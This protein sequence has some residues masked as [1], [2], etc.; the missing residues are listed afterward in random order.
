MSSILFVGIGDLNG[1]DRF[2]RTT[3]F[4]NWINDVSTY[5]PYRRVSPGENTV[6][7]H[8][9][10]T[11]WAEA[12]ELEQGSEPIRRRRRRLRG[13]RGASAKSL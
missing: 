1:S 2:I 3:G 9:V 6:N 11:V 5:R 10:Y 13:W 8:V 4:V 12:V 7:G